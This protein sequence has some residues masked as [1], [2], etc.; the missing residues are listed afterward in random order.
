MI[1]SLFL[2]CKACPSNR[3]GGAF[4]A[5]R[6]AASR[7]ARPEIAGTARFAFAYGTIFLPVCQPLSHRLVEKVSFAR[8]ATVKN[9]DGQAKV[10]RKTSR[11]AGA[12][13]LRTRRL[14]RAPFRPS[15][16]LAGTRRRL[17]RAHDTGP[18]SRFFFR[19]G[20]R[21]PRRA[22]YRPAARRSRKRRLPCARV[23]RARRTIPQSFLRRF[24]H[25]LYKQEE[26]KSRYEQ[27]DHDEKNDTGRRRA[28]PAAD[29]LRHAARRGTQGDRSLLYQKRP[30]FSAVLRKAAAAA[31][32]TRQR[33]RALQAL[34]CGSAAD[35]RLRH[36][37]SCCRSSA[38]FP[39]TTGGGAT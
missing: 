17:P 38:T 22:R 9:A 3:R 18:A 21:L 24:R 36:A 37:R 32:Q 13:R 1:P 8:P 4:S 33:G 15:G 12:R 2:F 27:S 28:R 19:L 7:K 30:R 29:R 31:R 14:R 16:V 39:S 11:R 20:F 23:V 34:R 26:R 25:M 35:D 6:P 5:G 10:R